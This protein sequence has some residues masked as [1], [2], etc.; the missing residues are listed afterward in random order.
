MLA[1]RRR[2]TMLSF[3][4][5]GVDQYLNH[6]ERREIRCLSLD[7]LIDCAKSAFGQPKPNVNKVKIVLGELIS[8]ASSHPER[9]EE[10]KSRLFFSILRLIPLN[11]HKMLQALVLIFMKDVLDGT[12]AMTRKASTEME[13]IVSNQVLQSFQR[14]RNSILLL[15]R[16]VSAPNTAQNHSTNEFK[17]VSDAVMLNLIK[18]LVADES[19]LSE[20]YTSLGM[21]SFL[22][23]VRRAPDILERS[24]IHPLVQHVIRSIERNVRSKRNS[25]AVFHGILCLLLFEID[26]LWLAFYTP[27][28]PYLHFSPLSQLLLVRKAVEVGKHHFLS[29][30][31]HRSRQRYQ[32]PPHD[33]VVIEATEGIFRSHT[34]YTSATTG[35][36]FQLLDQ[37]AGSSVPKLRVVAL[38]I[39]QRY[40]SL[41]SKVVFVET[42]YEATRQHLVPCRGE[43][44]MEPI[45]SFRRQE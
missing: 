33:M 16:L 3:L 8:R 9:C 29:E 5:G 45:Q 22:H 17:F 2:R 31:I 28:F 35:P 26:A 40:A 42:F 34:S 18:E 25:M 12:P 21:V 32:R 39:L 37:Y 44:W 36:A 23:L 20:S 11:E 41:R 14:H 7:H 27:I 10:L 30:L 19:V 15:N 13:S 1:G 6:E 38:R 4:F 43:S 24:D